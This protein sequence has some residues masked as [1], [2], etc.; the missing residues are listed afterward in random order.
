[1]SASEATLSQELFD[2]TVFENEECFDLSPDEALRE[3]IN[4]FCQQLGVVAVASP[5]TVVASSSIGDE[6]P[7][8]A[9]HNDGAGN[10]SVV[11]PTALSHLVLSHPNSPDGKRDRSKRRRFQ[12]WLELLDSSVGTD[13]TVDVDI[14]SFTNC[15]SKVDSDG[16]KVLD[17]LIRISR[18]CRFGDAFYQDSDVENCDSKSKT[19]EVSKDN[20]C[21]AG[22]KSPLPFLTIFQRSSS[23]YTLMSFLSILDPT[24]LR[25]ND[26]FHAKIQILSA[27]ALTL[28]SILVNN[29]SN[30]DSKCTQIRSEL[31]DF[32]VPALSRLVCLVGGI[33]KE[34]ISS[35]TGVGCGDV[36]AAAD[37]I[38]L[39]SIMC[40]L[41][42]L[43]TNAT[44]GCEYAKVAWVQSTLL[45]EL[46]TDALLNSAGATKR[47]GVAVIIS[48]L[49]M[50]F[51]D[52]GNTG[53]L[54]E[55]CQLIASLCRYDDFRDATSAT[56]SPNT[57]SA[58]DHAMEFYRAGTSPLLIK[59][60][61]RVLL[62][63]GSCD[64]GDCST[65]NHGDLA[66]TKVTSERLA[67]A[68]LAALRVL[69]VNDEIIQ[70]MVALGIL[71]IVTK[72]LQSGLS[73]T[74]IDDQMQ[75][76]KQWIVAP[77]LG[78][79][80]NL[81]GNDEI[82][83]NLCLGST[84]DNSSKSSTPSILPNLL[85][86]MK[87][88][89]ATALIQEH[90]CGTLAAMAL[91]RPANARAILDAGGPRLVLA[92]MKRHEANVNVQ[93]QG[94]LAIRNIVSRLLRGLPDD[95]SSNPS[96]SSVEAGGPIRDVFLELGAEDVLR[97]I[98][99][100]HQGSVDEAYAALRDLGCKVSLLK[101]NADEMQ[102]GQNSVGIARTMMFGQKH[103]TNFR[104]VYEESVGLLNGVDNA[105]S[106][107]GS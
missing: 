36:S 40:E 91:R 8:A 75:K 100:R 88:F 106:R 28:S 31:R 33:A 101:F 38:S 77:S 37:Y 65:A 62:D 44:R 68:V 23:I 54:I 64:L 86:A 42:Q 55:A 84:N 48:C 85:H 25:V 35:S 57:S 72:G 34:M 104:P 76:R 56:N 60:A 83:T 15:K 93:R 96:T 6:L 10:V 45:P 94:S 49:S 107:F 87:M 21:M 66:T 97:N 30:D 59:I 19:I 78:L 32:F 74:T 29:P 52:H 63:L 82:K 12:K 27:T 11:V 26:P 51:D 46:T 80:R 5:T 92:A 2:E 95:D 103:N 39:S 50:E 22:S 47:G 81:S 67:S 16:D 69:A 24:Q 17:A 102:D 70:T 13:G 18:C 98:A 61:K 3:T 20:T 4:Q 9:C 43:A 41:L 7:S 14:D 89:S 105:V 53:V 58:H 99:G 71:P 79:L 73:D 90:A 1:M